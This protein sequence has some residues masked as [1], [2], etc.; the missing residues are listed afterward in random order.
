[1]NNF[2]RASL[3]FAVLAAAAG[4]ACSG[5]KGSSGPKTVD[6]HGTLVY[7]GTG[8]GAP[9]IVVLTSGQ[10]PVTTAA[11]GTFS[12]AKLKTPYR[13]TFIDSTN[14][15]GVIWDGL[16]IAAP[17][18]PWSVLGVSTHGMTFDGTVTGLQGGSVALTA[19]APHGGAGG[20]SVNF[21]GGAI[22]GGQVNWYGPTTNSFTL[23][24]V[25]Y[26]LSSSITA[27]GSTTLAATD[28]GNQSGVAVPMSTVTPLPLTLDVTGVPANSSG[29]A[30]VNL[31]DANSPYAAPLG[32]AVLSSSA[33]I[34][35]PAP[36]VTGATGLCVTAQI[37]VGGISGPIEESNVYG[38][39]GS[40]ATVAFHA[41]LALALPVD[42]ATGVGLATPFSWGADAQP[43]VYRL[44]FSPMTGGSPSFVVYTTAT[45]ATIPDLSV[46]GLALPVGQGYH[47]QVLAFGP[48]SSLDAFADGGAPPTTGA[49]FVD[50][51]PQRSFSTQ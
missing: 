38:I 1:M 27:A 51:A 25:G 14:K 26:G 9:G 40:S 28:G 3:A 16:T 48:T 11:D 50:S 6:V 44:V 24:A 13:L 10:S 12:F 36:H 34:S 20:G 37:A 39:T 7:E 47:W 18:I 33:T 2:A 31:S 8:V 17:V 45:S 22:T 41:P 29:E 5:K 30:S 4:A 15:T 19:T 42:G 21:S 23:W 46:Q 32:V 35:M 43:A 49:R